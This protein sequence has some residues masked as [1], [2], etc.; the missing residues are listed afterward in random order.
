MNTAFRLAM[1][2][3]V[4]GGFFAAVALFGFLWMSF[5][6]SGG[7]IPAFAIVTAATLAVARQKGDAVLAVL[8][9]VHR[10]LPA[11]SPG[12]WFFG[13]VVL[14]ATVRIFMATLFPAIPLGNWNWDMIRYLDLAH[15]LEGGMDYA[16]P[17]GRAFWAP[18]LPLA[19]ALLL[20]VFGSSAAL[21]YNIITFVIATTAT[22]LLGRMLVGWRV[23][24]L[25]A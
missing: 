17:E 22:F 24:C 15:K 4:L 13:T 12:A 10:V 25:A 7:F 16:T 20:P 5:N 9:N 2:S 1:L 11:A 23:G 6:A 8:Y 19:L 3:Q 18:G 21:A 14:G